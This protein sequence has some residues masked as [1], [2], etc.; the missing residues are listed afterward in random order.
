MKLFFNDSSAAEIGTTCASM[1]RTVK[2]N[3]KKGPDKDY[4]AFR[5]FTDRETEG[6]IITRWMKFVG[7]ADMEGI[8]YIKYLNGR[9]I[10][11]FQHF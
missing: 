11:Y 2:S 10:Q 1:N 3:G 5:D 9:H 7:M 8:N 6:H 4:N